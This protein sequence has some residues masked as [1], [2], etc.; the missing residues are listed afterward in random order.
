MRSIR[1][2]Q[3]G[4]FELGQITELSPEAGQHVGVVLRMQP[5]ER[6]TLFCGDNREF[7]ARI[8][9]V[10]KKKVSVTIMAIESVNRESPRQ[11]HLAQA[12]SKGDRMEW[13]IQKAVELGVSSITPLITAHCAVRLDEARLAKK[14]QQWQAIAVSACEQCGRN[15]VPVIHPTLQFDAL[16]QHCTSPLKLILHPTATMSWQE[17]A[18][19][20]GEVTLLIGPE[21]GLSED[22]IKRAQSQ[23]FNALALGPR[24]LRTE[25]A[26]IAALSVLQ[27]K[28]GDL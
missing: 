6:L 11:I 14:Q 25:T 7:Q 10:R 22:E 21:G 16:I 15:V 13:V 23:Q 1:I 5:D 3:E 20:E 27:A 17:I 4:P 28:L 8:T 24:I 19:C 2:F 12:I 26:A 9:D 18:T